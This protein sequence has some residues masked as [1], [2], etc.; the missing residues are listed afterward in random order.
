MGADDV[1]L[2]CYF[3]GK[4]I[5]EDRDA[6][7]I[8]GKIKKG[9]VPKSIGFAGFKEKI[10]EIMDLQINGMEFK[11][12]CGFSIGQAILIALDVDDDESLRSVVDDTE[13]VRAYILKDVPSPTKS[14]ATQREDL[15]LPVAAVQFPAENT[16]DGTSNHNPVEIKS[17]GV[18]PP[19]NDGMSTSRDALPTGS[20]WFHEELLP[21][22][23]GHGNPS[24][25][26][27]CGFRALCMAL[28]RNESEWAWMRTELVK[29]IESNKVLYHRLFGD[30]ETC[31][32]LERTR[33]S[34]GPAPESRWMLM[35]Y[36]GFVFAQAFKVVLVYYFEKNGY[37]FVPFLSPP[38]AGNVKILGIGHLKNNHYIKL[39]FQYDCQLPPFP[40]ILSNWRRICPV[41][42]NSWEEL[43]APRLLTFRTMN[44]P[45]LQIDKCPPETFIIDE[46]DHV[47]PSAPLQFQAKNLV[48]GTSNNYPV[49]DIHEHGDAVSNLDM[50]RYGE[51]IMA[52][53]YNPVMDVNEHG[54]VNCIDVT[55]VNINRLEDMH[56]RFSH[57]NVD[58]HDEEINL[59]VTVSNH[60]YEGNQFTSQME[61]TAP[62]VHIETSAR[63]GSSDIEFSIGREFK[64]IEAFR[65]IFSDWAVSTGYVYRTVRKTP[66]MLT[67]KCRSEGC[68]WR[69]QASKLPNLSTCK[70]IKYQKVHTCSGPQLSCA[71]GNH[72]QATKKW[73][74]SKMQS[75][76]ERNPYME[77]KKIVKEIK[78]RYGILISYNKAVKAKTM[79]LDL[80]RNQKKDSYPLPRPD[81]CCALVKE[82]E[83]GGTVCKLGLSSDG[84]SFQHLFW[85]FPACVEALRNHLRPFIY[86]R[87]VKIEIGIL[88]YASGIDG[89]GFYGE[90]I[91]VGSAL[92]AREDDEAWDTFLELTVVNLLGCLS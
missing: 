59:P 43:L 35:P 67:M 50:T 19:E 18:K 89:N 92:C 20:E 24:S 3:G 32:L 44:V 15:V 40:H 87:S 9:K 45:E 73:I 53:N 1:P 11:I 90:S 66:S 78:D 82:L 38:I 62:N 27:N 65:N 17:I 56:D 26:G 16:I 21:F 88:M 22:V 29:E 52:S 49:E 12:K 31:T 37:T 68:D 7:Y 41:I 57:S 86:V 91:Q 69:I 61:E 42:A 58:Q 74:V 39:D 4:L 71:G 6:R 83:G 54:D 47:L 28:G 10:K 81:I 64:D 8:G 25:D 36:T 85:A 48:D 72:P 60:E 30:E 75:S 23:T 5:D 34:Y 76:I 2:I 14:T 84:G 70:V 51:L 79:A 46:E 55:G 80:M 63:A 77:P 13:F 33:H